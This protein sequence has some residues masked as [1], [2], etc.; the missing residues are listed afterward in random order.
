MYIAVLD[1]VLKTALTTSACFR[2]VG[3]YHVSRIVTVLRNYHTHFLLFSI[4]F[5]FPPPPKQG[6][7]FDF[8]RGERGLDTVTLT[9]GFEFNIQDPDLFLNFEFKTCPSC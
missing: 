4:G 5:A 3:I 2:Q 1:F 7:V 9:R 8:Y 6:V